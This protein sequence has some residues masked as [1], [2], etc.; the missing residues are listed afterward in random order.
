MKARVQNL[1]R[2]AA[3]PQA[4]RD[5]APLFWM[6]AL[7][8]GGLTVIGLVMVLSA[9]SVML[10]SNDNS[11]WYLFNRQLMFGAIG[12]VAFIVGARLDYR[13][14]LRW[15]PWLLV[16]TIIFL[17][18]VL[19]PG[20]GIRANGAQRWIGINSTFG[21]QP[22]EFAKLVL[23]LF[24][25]R[26]LARRLD[27]IEDAR[28]VLAP[29]LIVTAIVCV[30]VMLE[31]DL[32]TAIE[33]SLIVTGILFAA[34]I[35]RR[36]LFGL[37]VGNF[38]AISVLAVAA[39]YRF[40]RLLTFLHPEDD[41][42]STGYQI[43]QSLIALGNGGWT[44]VG[45][46]NGHA[47]WLFLPAAH[48]DFIFSIIGEETGVVGASFVLGLFG[49]FAVLGCKVALRAPDRAGMLLAA[50]VTTWV[51]GQALINVA[52]VVG[53]APVSGTPLPFISAGGTSLVVLMG[54]V[55]ILAN[56]ARQCSLPAP[57]QSFAH[58]AVGRARGMRPAPSA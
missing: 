33:I 27:Q 55:G 50:G 47:K 48:T 32:D 14:W 2:S 18:A 30:L 45:L 35:P 29:L 17:A 34:G 23:L 8:V 1:W 5:G 20:V 31:P 6:I 58:P 22:S 53:L 28:K 54:S 41:P 44:G 16:A 38:V 9:S 37:L 11:A 56:V 52:M 4:T 49:V 24:A 15:A 43:K 25:A 3:F 26:L 21:F 7:L 12:T 46:G 13:V 42:L 57:V 19:I 51:C 40:R 10:I 36:Q 39:P